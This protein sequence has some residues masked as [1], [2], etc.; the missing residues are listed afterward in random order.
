MEKTYSQEIIKAADKL[1][2]KY[3]FQ[4][5]KFIWY[6]C[7]QYGEAHTRMLGEK[8]IRYAYDFEYFAFTKSAKT[9]IS[10][11]NLLKL[12]HNE[13]VLILLRSVFENYLASRY[14]SE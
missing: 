6:A 3:I 7:F 5:D 13:D 10:I 4:S 1:I 12:N 11:R 8:S 14:F 9:L 2:N